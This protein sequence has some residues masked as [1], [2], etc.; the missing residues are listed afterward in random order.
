LADTTR[1]RHIANG[2]RDKG[3]IV[4]VQRRFDISDLLPKRLKVI[5]DAELFEGALS[6]DES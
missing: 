4:F 6:R 2:Y 3:R 1:F 5:G